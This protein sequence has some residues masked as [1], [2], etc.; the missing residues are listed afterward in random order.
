MLI[1]FYAIKPKLRKTFT[2]RA[3]I[4]SLKIY[5]NERA[6]MK[7]MRPKKFLTL[8]LVVKQKNV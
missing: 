1:P 5:T 8:T 6:I 2:Y 7:K 3:R 4:G